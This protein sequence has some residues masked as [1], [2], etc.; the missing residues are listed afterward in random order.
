MNI[1]I[2]LI[3]LCSA[4]E[5]PQDLAIVGGRIEYPDG[6]VI[7]RG[8]IL[9]HDG[10]IQSVGTELVVP[11]IYKTLDA[12]GCTVLAGFIDSYS[13]RGMTMPTQV[14]EAIPEKPAQI[15]PEMDRTNRKGIRPEISAA[16]QGQLSDLIAN[17]YRKSGFVSAM[18]IPDAGILGGTGSLIDFGNG[19][20]QYRVLQPNSG[21]AFGYGDSILDQK[22]PVYPSSLLGAIALFRQTMIDA[23]EVHHFDPGLDSLKPVLSKQIPL[24]MTVRSRAEAQRAHALEHEFNFRPI[25]LIK[26][27]VEP[28]DIQGADVIVD[29]QAGADEMKKLDAENI[30]FGVCSNPGTPIEFFLTDLRRYVREG[31]SRTSALKALTSEPARIFRTRDKNS[32]LPG[33]PANFT[34][35]TGEF[36]SETTKLK[37]LIIRGTQVEAK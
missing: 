8:T 26:G 3:I 36:E 7:E 19:P 9:V 28:E 31:L 24:I 35:L 10:V 30:H 34:I 27:P 1:L 37:A 33:E 4:Q 29:L 17:D 11:S 15:Y 6:R 16:F 23:A 14:N 22:V 21:V 2:P 12:N 13:S 5:P 32:M 25:F 20:W 18:F